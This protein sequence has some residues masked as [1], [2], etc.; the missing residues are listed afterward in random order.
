MRMIVYM[1]IPVY[2]VLMYL[3]TKTVIDRSARSIAYMKVFGYHSREVS[4]LYVRS[5]TI[6]VLASLVLSLPLVC[7]LTG[8]LMDVVMADYSGN[9]E[10]WVPWYLLVQVVAMGALS[11][12]V[13]AAIHLWRIRR[14]GLA[15]ALKVQE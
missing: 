5:I 1:V 6:T 12:A 15:D 8:L 13:V 2:F 3:L 10:L 11:Y 4:A 9:I 7:W 14:I